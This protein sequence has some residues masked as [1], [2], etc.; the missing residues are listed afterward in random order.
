MQ[1]WFFAFQSVYSIRVTICFY[2]INNNALLQK[3]RVIND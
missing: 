1:M 3:I 2:Y